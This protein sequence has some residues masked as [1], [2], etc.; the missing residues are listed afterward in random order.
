MQEELKLP[1]IGGKDS[2][3]GTFQTINVPPMLMAFGI[4]T[5]NANN[6][7]S[8]DLKSAGN[9]LYLIRHTPK[10]NYMPDTKQ[11][12]VNFNFISENIEKKVITSAYA[13]GFGGVSEAIA[14]MA[15]GNE[16]GA[17]VTINE[18]DLFDYNYGSILIETSEQLNFC[19]A[20]LIGNTIDNP[21]LIIK[22]N[23]WIK[24]MYNAIPKILFRLSDK[25]K[26]KKKKKIKNNATLDAKRTQK[27]DMAIKKPIE[28]YRLFTVFRTNCDY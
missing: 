16:I 18:S 6:V 25:N 19:N 15:F 12:A 2:M 4:T 3:S 21:V 9:Q 23:K 1:S 27:T 7:I 10:H 8:T 14:K 17:N 22:A 20:E 24:A 26:K 13:I 5:V 11:L 28:S